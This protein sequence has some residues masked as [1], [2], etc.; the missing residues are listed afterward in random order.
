M[1]GIELNIFAPSH[2]DYNLCQRLLD[3]GLT[4]TSVGILLHGIDLNPDVGELIAERIAESKA[5]DG[6]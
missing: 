3:I 6:A 5:E 2:P 4:A 1:E